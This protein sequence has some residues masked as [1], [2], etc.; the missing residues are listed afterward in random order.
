MTMAGGMHGPNAGIAS[1]SG[2]RGG[3]LRGSIVR[4]NEGD[5]PWNRKTIRRRKPAYGGGNR[6]PTA[7]GLSAGHSAMPVRRGG[8]RVAAIMG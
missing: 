3:R 2:R 8:L 1:G 5:R 4:M 7:C 6:G